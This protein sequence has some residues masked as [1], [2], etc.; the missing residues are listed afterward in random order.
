MEY[1]DLRMHL[2]D[3]FDVHDLVDLLNITEDDIL[4]EFK[5]KVIENEEEVL[6]ALG[7]DGTEEE[8]E[9]E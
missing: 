7:F 5:N 6:E 8:V 4:D 3:R 9:V 1:E 2:K